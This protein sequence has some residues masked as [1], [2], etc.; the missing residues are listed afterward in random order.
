V[1]GDASVSD[2]LLGVAIV[3]NTRGGKRT[4]G[5]CRDERPNQMLRASIKENRM[6][7]ATRWLSLLHSVFFMSLACMFT[8]ACQESAETGQVVLE[9]AQVD[10]QRQV[11]Q[12]MLDYSTTAGQKQCIASSGYKLFDESGIESADKCIP[13]CIC[14][15]QEGC[16]CCDTGDFFGWVMWPRPGPGVWTPPAPV[17]ELVSIDIDGACVGTAHDRKSPLTVQ[18][19]SSSRLASLIDFEIS[20][21]AAGVVAAT[22]SDDGRYHDA[23]AGDHVMSGEAMLSATAPGGCLQLGCHFECE[24]EWVYPSTPEEGTCPAHEWWGIGCL[25]LTSCSFGCGTSN[26]PGTVVRPAANF[27]QLQEPT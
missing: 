21:P 10:A 3:R 19:R 7:R 18:T 27:F 4:T 12:C 17:K 26:A 13:G 24:G 20:V 15:Q 9:L 1:R 6:E 22:V 5:P 8:M 2:L 23:L 16:P 11:E 25:K 14:V